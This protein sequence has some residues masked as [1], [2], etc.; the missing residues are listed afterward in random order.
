MRR[1]YSDNERVQA[2]AALALNRGNIKATARH[3]GIPHPTLTLWRNRAEAD[4]QAGPPPATDYGAL[5]GEAQEWA[6]DRLRTLIPTATTIRDLAL[7]AAIAADRHLDY[8]EGRRGMRG[9]R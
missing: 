3:L 4:R 1:V 8:A 5:Y 6:L 7:V 9:G 2:L